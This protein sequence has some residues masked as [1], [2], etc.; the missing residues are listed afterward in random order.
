LQ[1]LPFLEQIFGAGFPGI[2]DCVILATWDGNGAGFANVL[3]DIPILCLSKI[4]NIEWKATI[5]Y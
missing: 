5:T 2:N 1:Q 4:H 3:C